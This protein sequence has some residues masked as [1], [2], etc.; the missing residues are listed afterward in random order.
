MK[1]LAILFL[2]PVLLWFACAV[3]SPEVVLDLADVDSVEV[4]F[5]DGCRSLSDVQE[6][7]GFLGGLPSDWQAFWKEPP[8]WAFQLSLA[9]GSQPRLRL[10]V[11]AGQMILSRPDQDL[12]FRQVTDTESSRLMALVGG[13]PLGEGLAP[14]VLSALPLRA[15]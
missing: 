6:L 10:G 12:L 1:A 5:G 11:V 13:V 4:Q 7:L 14:C 8:T 15:L 2:V 9:S 3:P